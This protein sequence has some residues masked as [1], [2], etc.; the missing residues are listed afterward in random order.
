MLGEIVEREWLL[1]PAGDSFRTLAW[2]IFRM[3]RPGLLDGIALRWAGG[4]WN[5]GQ[6]LRVANLPG[7][8]FVYLLIYAATGASWGPPA[9]ELGTLAP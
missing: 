6:S 3:P 8:L 2:G 1:E 7:G 4:G 5:C 9:E